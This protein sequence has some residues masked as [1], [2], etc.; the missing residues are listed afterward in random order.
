[1]WKSG[2]GQTVLKLSTLGASGIQTAT[3]YALAT[4]FRWVRVAVL[5]MPVVP[6]VGCSTAGSAAVAAEANGV[7]GAAASR[8]KRFGVSAVW[9]C[10][11]H[12]PSRL[13]FSG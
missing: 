5:G 9:G 8:R 1:M 3:W 6:P 13:A 11:F 7:D 12:R 4:R 10:G 2:S